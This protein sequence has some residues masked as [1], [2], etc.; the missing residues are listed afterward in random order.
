MNQN[1]AIFLTKKDYIVF[2]V[3]CFAS[4]YI[5][6]LGRVYVGELI[7]FFLYLL[8]PNTRPKLPRELRVISN[9]LFVWLASAI[10]TD[11]WRGTPT[12]DSIKGCISIIFLIILIPFV[13]WALYD[14][15]Q[16]WFVFYLGTIVSSQLTYYLLTSQTE[17]G[18][19]EIWRT[20]SYS[21][22]FIGLSL[23]MYWKG[24]KTLSYIVLLIFGVW[25]LYNGSR[26]IF[27]T[28]SLTV[29]ILMIVNR[30]YNL[31]PYY[32]MLQYRGRTSFLFFALIIGCLIVDKVYETLAANGSLGKDAYEKY[33]RQSNSDFGLASG[34][35]E[36]IMDAELIRQSPIIGY[37]SF[38]KDKENFVNR[39]KME[40]NMPINNK[41]LDE[42][43]V[44]NMLPRHSRIGGLWMWHGIGAGVFWVYVIFLIYKTFR[45]GSFLLY[46][47]LV[48]LTIYTMMSEMWNIF[49]SIMAVRLPFLF[50]IV[51]LV[52]IN[53]KT[54]SL[55]CA[56]I[57]KQTP[58]IS[59]L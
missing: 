53:K 6:L 28:C 40:H 23:L 52:I 33:E 48:A 4:F 44:E 49:F 9:L 59:Q 17:A 10:L 20:Y 27:L 2:M 30:S 37:G 54:K 7:I 22:L 45:N 34:R 46:P 51:Y 47:H 14:R 26:N 55:R 3:G 11:L 21:P 13:Y 16:R 24:N 41:K 12:I 43:S 15:P 50:L 58:P 32:R 56:T 38:A 31:T 1:N 35:L 8:M 29:V 25:A 5:G 42:D 57:P 18:S 36:A 39:F 19:A